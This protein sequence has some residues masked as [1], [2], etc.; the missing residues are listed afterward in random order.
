MARRPAASK[1]KK[2]VTAQS[3]RS[4]KNT[5]TAKAPKRRESTAKPS[6]KAT[7]SSGLEPSL[8]SGRSA[9]LPKTKLKSEDLD[10]FKLLLLEKRRQLVGDMGHMEDEA[11]RKNRTDAAG[12]L[13]MMPIHMADIGTDAYE[14]EF[15]IG[16]IENE[17]EILTE[18]DAALERIEN[19]TYGICEATHR[20]IAKARL[21]V[22]PWARFCLTYRRSQEEDGR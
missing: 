3:R 7:H 19:G 9:P 6:R 5:N 16:L 11:L 2:K 13:S 8:P 10:A 1:I 17:K 21:K 14:Q 22:K 4:S 20:P 15:T 12:D 18:I